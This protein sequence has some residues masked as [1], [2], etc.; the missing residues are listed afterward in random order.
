MKVTILEKKIVTTL[1]LKIIGKK[2]KYIYIFL[3]N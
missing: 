2:I 3:K 1:V